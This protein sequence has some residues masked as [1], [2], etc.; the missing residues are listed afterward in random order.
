MNR[1]MQRGHDMVCEYAFFI[2]MLQA[3]KAILCQNFHKNME[4]KVTQIREYIMYSV[5]GCIG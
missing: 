2:I 5:T 3:G 4:K 1:Q